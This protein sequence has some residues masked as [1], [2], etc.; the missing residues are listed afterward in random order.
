MLGRKLTLRYFSRPRKVKKLPRIINH[1]ELLKIINS[2]P[3]IKH[4]TIIYLA[5]S[6]GMRISEICNVMLTDIDSKR[7]LI[8][9]RS[10]KGRKDRYVPM[11]KSLLDQLQSYY[12]N[13][14]EKPKTYLFESYN[15]KYSTSSCRAIW[16][17]YKTINTNFHTIRHSCFT[18][19]LETG[20]DIRIIQKIAGHSNIKTTEI[21]THVSNDILNK[22]EMPI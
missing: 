14:K 4:K 15:I 20:T 5:Y 8:L 16:N 3:N 6:T 1:D 12:S 18:R 22:V 21:Y 7:M 2:I 10:G 11:S 9:I 17:K 13:Y 19:L